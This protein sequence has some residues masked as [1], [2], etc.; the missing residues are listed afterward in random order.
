MK[1]PLLVVLSA[2]ALAMTSY[3][4]GNGTIDS[5][6]NKED[7]G[8]T[9]MEKLSKTQK[10]ELFLWLAE[11]TKKVAEV[12]KK[13]PPAAADA[14]PAD[15][16]SGTVDPGK[17]GD[18]VLEKLNVLNGAHIVAAD[19]TFL[20]VVSKDRLDLDS[21]ANKVGKFGNTAGKESIFN[22]EGKYGGKLGAQSAFNEM[23]TRPPKI[24]LPSGKWT[25]LSANEERVP[26]VDPYVLIAWTRSK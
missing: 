23:C 20:G 4:Q 5:L 24:V 15:A 12:V 3:G 2:C 19:G 14:K 7:Q 26:R 10:R 1:M 22:D 25:Y 13:A 8:K 11:Y 9:G 6:M 16:T 17:P 18:G 21:I